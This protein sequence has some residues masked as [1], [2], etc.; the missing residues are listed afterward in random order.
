MKGLL[1]ALASLKLTVGL[2]VAV[3]LLMAASLVV[4]QK[5]LLQRALYESWKAESP[6]LVEA[7]ELAGLT[8][9]HASPLADAVWALFFMNLAVVMARRVPVTAARVRIDGDVAD[10]AEA[11]GFRARAAVPGA[12]ATIEEVAAFFRARRWAVH[13]AGG[14]LRA[15]RYRWSPAA[16]L[17]FHLSFILVAIGAAVSV[18][19]RFEAT[20]DLGEGEPFLASLDQYSSRP[21][22]PRFGGIPTTRFTVEEIAPELERDVPV[23][24]RVRVVDEAGE[25]HL[26]EV[27]RPYEAGG[28]SFVFRTMGFAPALVVTDAAGRT[29]FEGFMRLDVLQG[30]RDRFELMG[31]QFTAELFPDHE[32][33]PSGDRTRSQQVRNPVLRLEARAPSGRAMTAAL[34]PGEAME[35][36][37][38]TLA[39]VDWRYWVRLY[40]R[41]E[42]GL[43][44]L[45]LGFALAAAALTLRL[46]FFRREIL[47]AV[48]GDGTVELA[49]RAEYYRA[50]FTDELEA[51]AAALRRS[52]AARAAGDPPAAEASSSRR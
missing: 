26:L 33:G 13:R 3:G 7:L 21:R 41:S 36:G 43:W 39:F 23:A 6:A 4:P 19:T 29:R 28:T 15:V 30:R 49:G 40:V 38:Y 17:G 1:D 24:V 14:R 9:V 47:A 20:V 34:H 35:L 51:I 50:L 12:G 8:D 42:R 31:V 2:L 45:W 27:N 22:F 32:V 16:T 48:S 46:G 11:P 5:A 37:P 44:L 10:P 25:R 18:A 52:L